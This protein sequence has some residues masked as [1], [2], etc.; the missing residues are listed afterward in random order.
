MLAPDSLQLAFDRP[1]SA[2]ETQALVGP[3]LD[4]G[5]SDSVFEALPPEI[6]ALV[7]QEQDEA[8]R[9]SVALRRALA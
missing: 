8:E 4:V 1:V 5:V 2:V 9:W 7:E 3:A 6:L